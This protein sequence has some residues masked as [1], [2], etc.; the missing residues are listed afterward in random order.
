MFDM[1]AIADLDAEAACAA[2][3]A[4]QAELREREWRELV[5]AA[6]WATLHDPDT[7]P[8]RD[9]PVLPGSERAKRA[10]GAG[11]PQITEFACA[12]LGLLMGTGYIAADRL[13]SDAVDLQ[14]RHPL[15][16]AA[17]AAGQG[18]VWKA[19]KVAGMTKSANL[20]LEQ[21][22]FVDAATTA[23]IDSLPWSKFEALV[24]AKII[25]ADPNAA[26]VRRTAA[27]M[28]RFVATGQSDEH[29]LKTL[30]ARAS[31]GDVIYFV[32]VCDR[33]AQVLAREGDADPVDVLRSK[34]IGIL[35]QPA[36]A[37]A[38]LAK[39]AAA[40]GSA[41]D[42]PPHDDDTIAGTIADTMA[43]TDAPAD[44]DAD[45]D[46]GGTE[47]E[48]CG[49][50]GQ[51]PGPVTFDPDRMRARAV[52]HVRI[53]ELS[54]RSGAGVAACENPGVGPL[55]VGQVR[56]FLGHSHV[57][58]RPV[59][60]LR[61]QTPVDAYEVPTDM[62]ESLRLARPSTVFP[63]TATDSR[64]FDSAHSQP[65]V[66]REAGGPPGQTRGGHLGPLTRFPHRIKTHGR[67]WKHRQ[68]EP[69]TCLWRTPHGYWFR[70]DNTGTHPLGRD[71]DQVAGP[72]VA[73]R[74]ADA[75]LSPGEQHLADLIPTA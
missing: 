35:A 24:A 33:I 50:C 27:E 67:G 54:L 53:S 59:L 20:T 11:T 9:G 61:D 10:G 16:W 32:A 74:P 69:G 29:G 70:V 2:V 7:L 51:A 40:G 13:I 48:V 72:L 75:P 34:A 23:Y 57:T 71:P 12:E 19:R 56:E 37:L 49:T 73:D 17:L 6:H 39:H 28:A 60:D 64:T 65:Y 66:S 18:R 44:G 4:T 62:R 43:A 26:E 1:D 46:A 42:T 36:R 25:E 55:T 21:A 68:P 47:L 8:D 31:A 15:L 52:L 58:V 45:A 14:H 63:W 30:V 38:L 3:V 41:E 22:R 5:L